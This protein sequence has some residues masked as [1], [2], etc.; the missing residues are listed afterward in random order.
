FREQRIRQGLSLGALARVVGYRNVSKGS[1]RICRFER[2]GE[3]TEE[4]LVHLADAL[5]IDFSTVERLIEED[6]LDR[7]REWEEWVSQPAPMSLVVKYMPAVYGTVQLPEELTTMAQAE[8]W[9][10]DYARVHHWQ[11]C[12]VISRR[13]SVWIDKEGQVYART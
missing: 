8:R 11:V 2:N 6:R 3:I 13:M 1:N 5:G 7:L 12:L 9:A 4:L 10:C